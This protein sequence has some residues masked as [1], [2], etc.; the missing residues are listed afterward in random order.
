MHIV[1]SFVSILR[2]NLKAD[3]TKLE[4]VDPHK[5][6][7]E[8][9]E[10]HVLVRRAQ[11]LGHLAQFT[12]HGVTNGQKNWLGDQHNESTNVGLRGILLRASL[13]KDD[14]DDG[15]ENRAHGNDVFATHS[16]AKADDANDAGNHRLHAHNNSHSR[17]REVVEANETNVNGDAA[18]EAA[19]SDWQHVVPVDW[20]N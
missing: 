19:E 20:V 18:L 15:S 8:A 11:L 7:T 10:H 12:K 6:G 1:N 14:K 17:H 13:T 4:P 9:S 16:L 5:R 2:K 3:E